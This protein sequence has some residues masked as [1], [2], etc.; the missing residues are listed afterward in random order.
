MSFLLLSHGF[1]WNNR[2]RERVKTNPLFFCSFPF[3]SPF[4][5]YCNVL[6]LVVVW[7]SFFLSWLSDYI[8]IGTFL[9]ACVQNRSSVFLS[10]CVLIGPGLPLP[11]D[12]AP[13]TT[14]QCIWPAAPRDCPRTSLS[15]FPHSSLLVR[16]AREG[17]RYKRKRGSLK[18]KQR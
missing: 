9:T 16:R 5:L 15:L 2:Q 8:R 13:P 4:S 17:N 10:L 3:L 11:T 12:A 6:V 14:A 7:L 1:K 18:Y